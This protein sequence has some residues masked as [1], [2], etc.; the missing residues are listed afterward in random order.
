M[1]VG[2]L[3][4]RLTITFLRG[5]QFLGTA[6]LCIIFSVYI[7]WLTKTKPELEATTWLKAAAGIGGAG[8]IWTFL[9]FIFTCCF[10]G[11]S[12]LTILG[13]ILDILFIGANGVVAYFSRHGLKMDCSALQETNIN[14]LDPGSGWLVDGFNG[15]GFDGYVLKE[16]QIRGECSFQKSGFWVAVG[17][18]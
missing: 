6:S 12:S 10:G 5:I 11:V 4:G 7:A 16:W 15:S 17:L 2:Q 13:A 9:G 18:W 14:E 8:A 3:F 1:V